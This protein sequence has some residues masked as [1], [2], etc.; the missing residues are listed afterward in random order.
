MLTLKFGALMFVRIVVL[1]N[2]CRICGHEISMIHFRSSTSGHSNMSL[3]M[4]GN[5]RKPYI[6]LAWPTAMTH[7][8]L[9]MKSIPSYTAISLIPSA[10][11]VTHEDL[12]QQI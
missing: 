2:G 3:S 6:I 4:T 1:L 9:F 7:K 10:K 11:P 5:C 12:M 8:R